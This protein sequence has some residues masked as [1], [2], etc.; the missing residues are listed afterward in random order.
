M[1]DVVNLL[2]DNENPDASTILVNLTKEYIGAIKLSLAVYLRNFVRKILNTPPNGQMPTGYLQQLLNIFY[3]TLVDANIEFAIKKHLF[4][5][6]ESLLLIYQVQ[7]SN[8]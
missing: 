8:L 5:I 2:L 4:L 7:E 1:Q 3:M 6:F